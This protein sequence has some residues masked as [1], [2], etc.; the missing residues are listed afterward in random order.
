MRLIARK[1]M[2][3]LACIAV[4][5]SCT[6][7]QI[8]RGPKTGVMDWTKLVG[9]LTGVEYYRGIVTPETKPHLVAFEAGLTDAEV[10]Q[11]ERTYDFR[12]PPDL[13]GFLQTSL[14]TGDGFPDWRGGVDGSLRPWMDSPK[15]GILFDVEHNGS[16]M[17]D[18][19]I[20]PDSLDQAKEVAA[21]FIDAAPRLI[22]VFSHRMLPS[23]PNRAGNPVFSVHQTDIIYYGFDLEDY[24]RHEFK[25]RGRRPWPDSVRPI[26]F[27]SE[28]L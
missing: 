17:E 9:E 4:M 18:W 26:E 5:A 24:L 11:V 19:G 27:W 20:R 1:M 7:D 21:K 12:F 8:P 25:L 2:G 15:D 23:H 28:L 22:P 14:P 6:G 10:A 16:W 3:N 13:R